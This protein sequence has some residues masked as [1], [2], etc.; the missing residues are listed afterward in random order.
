MNKIVKKAVLAGFSA[1]LIFSAVVLPG[2]AADSTTEKAGNFFR[3]RPAIMHCL[4]GFGPDLAIHQQA[5]LSYLVKEYAPETTSEWEQAFAKRK[6]VVVRIKA[7]LGKE[8]GKELPKE[9]RE[10]MEAAH[11]DL[12]PEKKQKMMAKMKEKG[13]FSHKFAQAVEKHDRKAM[14]NILPQVLENYNKQTARMEKILEK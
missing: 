6:E 14:K 4:K 10:K 8:Q 1:C 7:K 9:K 12:T 3:E 5:Y 2:F 11:K 13:T